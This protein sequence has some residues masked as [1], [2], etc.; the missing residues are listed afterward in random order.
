MLLY[1]GTIE[2][3]GSLAYFNSDSA[4][5]NI[6]KGSF[7]YLNTQQRKQKLF[8]KKPEESSNESFRYKFAQ[9][10]LIKETKKFIHCAVRIVFIFCTSNLIQ[11]I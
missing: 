6:K 11:T 1:M 4:E 7:L 8:T 3:K 10:G 9:L 5:H 2:G